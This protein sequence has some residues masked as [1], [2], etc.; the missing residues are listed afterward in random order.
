M[1]S[2]PFARRYFAETEAETEPETEE[3]DAQTDD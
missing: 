2:S 3:G 1:V